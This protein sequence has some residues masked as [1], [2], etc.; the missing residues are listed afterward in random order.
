[1]SVSVCVCVYVCVCVCV[2]CV[3]VCVWC[4]CVCVC[5]ACVCVCCR[6]EGDTNR[7]QSDSSK[8]GTLVMLFD[9]ITPKVSFYLSNPVIT[10]STHISSEISAQ[11]LA[12]LPS[13]GC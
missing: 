11:L 9:V 5:C 3:C 2:L 7:L 13:P 6:H 12:V 10:L 4:V 1:M 8:C